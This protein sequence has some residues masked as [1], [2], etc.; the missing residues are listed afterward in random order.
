MYKSDRELFELVERSLYTAVIGDV[1]DSMGFLNQF[2]SPQIRPLGDVSI[3]TGRAMTVLEADIHQ[4]AAMAAGRGIDP[5]EVGQP[6]GRMLDALDGLKEGEIYLCAGASPNYALWGE[7]M[8]TRAKACG[9]RGAIM[10]GYHRD[11]K[12]ILE[13]G[14]PVF[15]YGNY[16][17]DQAPRGKVIDFRCPLRIGNVQVESGDLIVADIDGVVIVPRAIEEEVI[18]LAYE[19]ATGEKTV[20]KAIEGGLTAREAWDKYGI[21]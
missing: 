6:F 14:F 10:D 11:T 20:Q 1:M 2:L 15:S 9:S 7:L 19:K 21:L 3:L 8:S 17:Q 5:E 4:A 12:G 13:I 18:R 16:A